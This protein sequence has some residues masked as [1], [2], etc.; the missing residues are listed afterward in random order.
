MFYT[1]ISHA[2]RCRGRSGDCG[3]HWQPYWMINPRNQGMH[4][5]AKAWSSQTL[6]EGRRYTPGTSFGESV[7]IQ[8]I[9]RF[10]GRR[11]DKHRPRY[12]GRTFHGPCETQEPGSVADGSGPASV[13]T[14][15]STSVARRRR[16]QGYI[17]TP[18]M[19]S[20]C[21]ISASYGDR[22]HINSLSVPA[23]GSIV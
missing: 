22:H 7:S 3:A 1:E 8:V 10:R 12:P 13:R 2:R 15:S 6:A 20:G 11:S 18:A 17:D 23:Q 21:Q 5:T 4:E 14:L 16:L 19:R 9:V